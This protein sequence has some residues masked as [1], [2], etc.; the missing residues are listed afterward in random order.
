MKNPNINEEEQLIKEHI[1]L[2]NQIHFLEMETPYCVK[3]L[4]KQLNEENISKAFLE[5]E[6]VKKTLKTINE[7]PI[8]NNIFENL[9]FSYN[10]MIEI[11]SNI[12]V[13]HPISKNQG[14]IFDNYFATIIFEQIRRVVYMG[15]CIIG[16]PFLYVTSEP[17]DGYDRNLLIKFFKNEIKILKDIQPVNYISIR[18]Y[19]N[20]VTVRIGQ[21]VE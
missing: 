4:E 20:E 5:L 12:K 1:D 14:T 17:N 16:N 10:Q 6:K 18:K 21:L 11:I 19:F 9:L 13:Q 8:S 2:E 15:S 7:K 3:T